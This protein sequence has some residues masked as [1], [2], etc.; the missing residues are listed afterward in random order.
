[1]TEHVLL[2]LQLLKLTAIEDFVLKL[3]HDTIKS[4][5]K[6]LTILVDCPETTQTAVWEEVQELLS[7]LYV[8][9]AKTTQEFRK[10]LLEVDVLFKDWCGYNV[11]LERNK[12]YDCWVASRKHEQI[13]AYYNSQREEAGLDLVTIYS[14][15][16][17][18]AGIDIELTANSKKRYRPE[19]KHYPNVAV[20]GTFDHLHVGHK[21]LLTMGAW[22]SEKRLIC[23]VAGTEM[24]GK[25]EYANLVQS[26]DIRIEHVR[27]FLNRVKRGLV[28]EIVPIHDTYGPTSKDPD[29]QAIVVSKETLT[30]AYEI[31]RERSKRDFEELEIKI[32]QVISKSS[33]ALAKNELRNLQISSAQIREYLHSHPEKYPCT[34]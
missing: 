16:E 34:E 5:S 13:L 23:G 11:L 1:M 7:I 15:P 29:I 28:Y 26:L 24:L 22:L 33:R 3:V 8:K 17:E 19:E 6:S 20:G 30:G 32:I 31:N 14:I 27:K 12:S 25:K 4:T 21:I 10:P 2:Y 9:A 18:E